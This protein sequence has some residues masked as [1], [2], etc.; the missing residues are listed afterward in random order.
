MVGGE[1]GTVHA[2]S[3]E[4]ITVVRVCGARDIVHLSYILFPFSSY[5]TSYF[6]TCINDGGRRRTEDVF[7]ILLMIK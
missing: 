7:A 2:R 6:D 4:K 1:E 5:S 3:A